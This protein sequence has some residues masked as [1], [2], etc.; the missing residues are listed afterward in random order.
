MTEHVPVAVGD[1]VAD[2]VQEGVRVA[3]RVTVS[4]T[5]ADAEDVSV[6]EGEEVAEMVGAWI[7]QIFY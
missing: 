3:V 7:G 2:G 4:V 6:L 5:E 1:N